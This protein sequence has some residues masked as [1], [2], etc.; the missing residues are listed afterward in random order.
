[1]E[2]TYID[3]IKSAV[4]YDPHTGNFTWMTRSDVGKIWNSRYAG[5]TAFS[6]VLS[7]GYLSGSINKKTLLAHRV[8][9]AIYYGYFPACDIDHI[10]MDKK[11]NRI[12]NL[13]LSTR[14]Q[15]MFN[16]GKQLNNTSG[17]KGVSLHKPTG[18]WDA[19]ICV[20]KEKIYIGL[21]DTP[22][23]A[24]KAY[25]KMANKLHKEFSRTS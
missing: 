23:L 2:K 3:K 20:E 24:H 8:A 12:E 4:N 18:K 10:N 13:R 21:F 7:N 9:W 19:R 25:C 6:T 5:K 22:E 16:R 14:S 15:N 1:M 17:Y 11:D